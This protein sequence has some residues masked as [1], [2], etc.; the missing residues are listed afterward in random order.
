MNWMKKNLWI[1]SIAFLLICALVITDTY[2]LFETNATSD[3]ELDIGKW[4]IKLNDYDISLVQNITLND[5]IYSDNQHVEDNCF[6]PGRSAY[7]DVEIDTTLTDVSVSYNLAIDDS[8]LVDYPNIYFNIMDTDTNEEITSNNY[9]GVI[10]INDSNRVKTI[11]IFLVWDNNG[12]YDELDTSLINKNL[13]FTID[14]DF[15]QYVG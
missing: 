14:A 3:K 10:Y 13:N 2:A 9:S 7:F 15:L 12:E 5:F 11:R 6:A 8:S 1:L 4:V